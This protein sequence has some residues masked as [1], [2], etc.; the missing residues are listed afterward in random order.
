[1]R[2]VKATSCSMW[3]DTA[4]RRARLRFCE[5][6]ISGLGLEVRRVIVLMSSNLSEQILHPSTKL[7]S[8]HVIVKQLHARVHNRHGSQSI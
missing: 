6:L 2:A 1:M 4:W 5:G 7:M 3:L 8:F